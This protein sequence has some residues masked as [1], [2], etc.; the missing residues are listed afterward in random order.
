MS[1]KQ[2]GLWNKIKGTLGKNKNKIAVAALVLVGTAGAVYYGKDKV[3]LKDYDPRNMDW[4]KY[5][6]DI[7]WSKYDPRNSEF[8]WVKKASE[9]LMGKGAEV[10][11]PESFWNKT[12]NTVAGV[13]GYGATTGGSIKTKRTKRTK[14]TKKTKKTKKN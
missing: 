11:K 8:K 6:I 12:Y 9:Y 4:S 5:K 3:D 7:D 13:F 10:T 14:R 2:R 1:S